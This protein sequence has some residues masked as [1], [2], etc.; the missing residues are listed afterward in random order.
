[1]GS[2]DS[3]LGGVLGVSVPLRSEI[4]FSGGMVDKNRGD[5]Y[6]II[7][8]LEDVGMV[9]HGVGDEDVLRSMRMEERDRLTNANLVQGAVS[10]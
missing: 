8:I 10:Q 7:D 2:G 3:G 5:A 1:V 4:P 9:F 6:H